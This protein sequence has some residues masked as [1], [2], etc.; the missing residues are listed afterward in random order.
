M[1]HYIDKRD[2]ARESLASALENCRRNTY[3]GSLR[4]WT[5]TTGEASEPEYATA[6]GRATNVEDHDADTDAEEYRHEFHVDKTK[7]RTSVAGLQLQRQEF[8]PKLQA[9]RSTTAYRSGW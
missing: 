5:V 2:P 1:I 8:H 6:T 4:Q 3:S 7:Q 9:S